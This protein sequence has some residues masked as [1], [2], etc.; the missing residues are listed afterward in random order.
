MAISKK[1]FVESMK[2]AK[3]CMDQIYEK[4]SSNDDA[5]LVVASNTMPTDNAH[6]IRPADSST[7]TFEATKVVVSKTKPANAGTIWI[8]TN[9]E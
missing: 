2:N 7:I 9:G 1:T 4:K 5:C 3:V 6:W 8:N